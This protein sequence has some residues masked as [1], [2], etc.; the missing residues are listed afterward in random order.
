MTLKI[1]ALSQVLECIKIFPHK[2]LAGFVAIIPLAKLLAFATDQLSLRMAH[3][4][5]GLVNATLGNITIHAN[6]HDTGNSPRQQVIALRQC[7]L[8]IV[9]SSLIGSMLSNLLLVLG[10]CFFSGGM[11]FS[12]QG[13]NLTAVQAS[14]SLSMMTLA[15][16]LLPA[17]YQLM[18]NAGGATAAAMDAT[19]A[20]ILKTSRGMAIILLCGAYSF[21]PLLLQSASV[22]ELTRSRCTVYVCYMGFCL[23]T[24]TANLE[25]D[26]KDTLKSTPYLPKFQPQPVD[27]R[28][29]IPAMQRVE[30]PEPIE[31]Q[32]Q[33]CSS[34]SPLHAHPPSSPLQGSG[35]ASPENEDAQVADTAEDEPETPHLSGWACLSLLLV[36]TVLVAITAEFLVGSIN[37]LTASG[38]LSKEFVGIILLPIVGNAAEHVSAVTVAVKDKMSLSI[39]VAVGSSIQ[40]G[41]FVIPLSVVVAW[42][43][44]KPMTLLFDGFEAAS[45]VLAVLTVNYCL[46]D[47]KSNW[48]HRSPRPPL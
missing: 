1:V 8:G 7:E 13:F 22:R 6:F 47:G 2:N 12:E 25:D 19:Q 33:P 16:V 36:V 39:T 17:A 38:V 40:I 30:E 44:G 29:E 4:L 21:I 32:H 9:Q 42:G 46:Q 23:F 45:L 24:H 11:K 14:S 37:G 5:A 41:L 26:S 18:S 3:T 20:Q 10:M 34:G 31:L 15:A 43:M 28:I 35:E 27:P 48:V